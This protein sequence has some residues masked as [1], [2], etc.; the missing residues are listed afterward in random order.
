MMI[1]V[2][3]EIVLDGPDEHVEDVV[4]VLQ[5]TMND[6]QVIAPVPVEADVSYGWR[7]GE[8]KSWDVDRWASEPRWER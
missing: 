1:P 6:D 2:H 7:W 3:D 8:K 5:R 4:Q